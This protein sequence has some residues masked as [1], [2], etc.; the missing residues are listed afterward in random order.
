MAT[1]KTRVAEFLSTAMS[2]GES[3]SGRTFSFIY[4][5]ISDLPNAVLAAACG[6][7]GAATGDTRF[8]GITTWIVGITA[9]VS[10]IV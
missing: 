10:I 5:M 2:S 7:G 4:F 1:A 6:R 9:A 3:G 8:Q